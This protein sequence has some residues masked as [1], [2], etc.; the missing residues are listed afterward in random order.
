[1][2]LIVGCGFLGSYLA[3]HISAVSDE[4]VL[5][6][7]RNPGKVLQ[8][9]NTE[10][11]CCDIT[12]PQDLKVLAEKTADEKL[13]VYY[14]A[15]CHN[16]DFVYRCPDEARK[17]NITALQ[18]FLNAF[19]NIEKL[20]F[21]STD[22]VYGENG[23]IL[24]LDEKAELNPVSEYGRQK[25]EAEQIVV[26]KDFTVLRLPFML[27]PSL[28]GGR[29]HFYDRIKA[30]LQSG[31]SVEMID[32]LYRNVMSYQ[33]TAELLFVLSQYGGALPDVINVC[34]DKGMS[35][36]EMGCRLAE[37]FGFSAELIV[38][39]SEKEGEKFFADKRASSSIMDNSLL[40]TMLEIDEIKWDV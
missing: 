5:A 34:S 23:K 14:F 35:K 4:R 8:L 26:S 2:I 38:K 13:T 24:L 39:I 9:N 19:D 28:F 30:S 22:C 7:V 18:N 33:Q 37:H 3:K 16:V 6:V 17:I 15:A 1:M 21:A 10:Y 11:V 29:P 32:G 40:K 12:K 27:G 25:A 20:F 36:Y 31:Q